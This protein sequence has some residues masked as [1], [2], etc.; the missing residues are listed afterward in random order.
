MASP[1][2]TKRGSRHG[3]WRPRV[4]ISVGWPLRVTVRWGRGRLL[5]GFTA[6]RQT[7]GSPLLMPPSIPPWRLV[8][9]PMRQPLTPNPSPPGGEG[10]FLL[11]SP[12]GGE[13]GFLLPSPPGG[14][15]GF[16]L[17]SPPGGEGLGV[18]GTNT[19]LFSLPRAV[20]TRKP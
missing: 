8:S 7:T 19:S 16:L 11:P 12:P 4:A 18:R 10:R 20:A 2:G 6:T 5:V 9:V 14:E 17:P 3:S 1:I 15:G 13:G